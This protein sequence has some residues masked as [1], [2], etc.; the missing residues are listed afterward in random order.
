MSDAG[1]NGVAAAAQPL[2]EGLIERS[3]TRSV[4]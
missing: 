3:E 4:H 2:H 1:G